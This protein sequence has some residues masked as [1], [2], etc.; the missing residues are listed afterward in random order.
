[1]SEPRPHA[2]ERLPQWR[3]WWRA[4]GRLAVG[5][6]F[7]GTL[8]PIV[9]DPDAA[10]PLPEAVA[11][12]ERLA[13]RA[14]ARVA[15]LSGRALA[16]LRRRLPVAGVWMAGNHGLEVAD[17][18]GAVWHH[19]LAERA[20]ARVASVAAALAQRARAWPGVRVENK[21]STLSVHVRHAG[22]AVRVQV[23][24]VVREC[25]QQEGWRLTRG[26]EV[27]ELRPTDAWHKGEA[28]GWLLA[29]WGWP[30]TT[31]VLYWGD[32][33]T[34]EDVFEWLQRRDAPGEGIRV[35]SPTTPTAATAWVENPAA[36]ADLLAA[37]AEGP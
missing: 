24:D 9:P 34:D 2:S 27:W 7:D 31:P 11:A 21:G 10:W 33:T 16:D 14:D 4:A 37:L 32:D 25:A 6:D 15:V 23:E 1:M 30:A 22:D 13:A 19:P 18:A 3:A 12:V 17:P 26:L 20:R 35:G 29:R 28:L 5:L 8:A 36:V